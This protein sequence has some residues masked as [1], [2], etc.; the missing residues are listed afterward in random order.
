[1]DGEHPQ[2]VSYDLQQGT[3]IQGTHFPCVDN[4]IALAA[5]VAAPGVLL[6]QRKGAADIYR[7]EWKNGRFSF[8]QPW[9]VATD[10]PN[11]GAV[12]K[13]QATDGID[14]AISVNGSAKKDK[15]VLLALG[16]N[17]G[18]AWWVQKEANDI[19]LHTWSDG[20]DNP[21]S[22]RYA[23]LAGK[24]DKAKWLGGTQVLLQDLYARSPRLIEIHQKIAREIE[25]AHLDTLKFDHIHV[26][27][28]DQ[29]TLCPIRIA[30][31]VVQW[32]DSGLQASDQIMLDDGQ[33]I[34]DLMYINNEVYALEKGGLV[35]HLLQKDEGGVLRS[36][37]Q[38]DAPGG[39]ALIKDAHIGLILEHNTSVHLLSYG[40]HHMLNLQQ[41]LDDRRIRAKGLKESTM[42]RL[43]AVDIY[44]A[45]SKQVVVCDD[46][47]HR[48]SIF[49]RNKEGLSGISS[50]QVYEDN[51]YPYGHIEEDRVESEP[52]FIESLR[53]DSD[54]RNDMIMICHDRLLIY[55]TTKN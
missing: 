19:I 55:S 7:S 46:Y 6:M 34:I 4:I 51:T 43:F 49:N 13:Q 35:L 27:T 25:S 21:Q 53:F 26:R 28:N 1:I 50:W 44:P 31:G 32:L 14:N 11:E 33:S 29:D 16:Q 54:K 12:S 10:L 36:V 15:H 24:A 17:A 40:S 39:Q 22:Q 48:L 38:Y 42:H 52:R 23:N 3:W 2:I 37:E 20:D 45:L 8:P 47:R 41:S 9:R 5:P 18:V 30:D